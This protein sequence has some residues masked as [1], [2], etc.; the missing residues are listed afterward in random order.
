M[1]I[2][3]A[4]CEERFKVGDVL[5]FSGTGRLS[6]GINLAT[7][8]V[9][10]WGISHVG[11]I[12][13]WQGRLVLYESTINDDL[14]CVISKHRFSGVQA[15]EIAEVI[16]V[17]PGRVWHYSLYRSLYDHESKRLHSFLDKKIGTPYDQLG[18]IRSAGAGFS[19][20]ESIFRKENLEWIYCSELLAATF[21]ATGLYPI[22]NASRWNPNR[23]IRRLRRHRVLKRPERI[24]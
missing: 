12:G 18:A 10:G 3:Y 9:P 14:P 22:V 15:H 1:G 2:S 13:E 16:S 8:G 7:Y 17:Y 20:I 4:D 11:I 19:W 6:W 24:K 23:L 5:G 21:A